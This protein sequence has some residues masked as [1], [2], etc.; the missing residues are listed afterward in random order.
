MSLLQRKFKRVAE[1]HEGSL[2]SEEMQGGSLLNSTFTSG[3]ALA[4]QEASVGSTASLDEAGYS[5]V[6]ALRS[7]IEMEVFMRRA[8][9]RLDVK[10]V[11]EAAFKAS[12]PWFSGESGSSNYGD[13]KG[14]FLNLLE[15]PDA[16]VMDS[17]GSKSLTTDRAHAMFVQKSIKQSSSGNQGGCRGCAG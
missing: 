3:L 16:W 9:E 8:L 6:L 10:I 17:S 5:S 7:N 1:R 4:G 15:A 14:K 12:V 2:A 11:N 13:L